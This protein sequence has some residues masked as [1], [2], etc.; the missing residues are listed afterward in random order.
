MHGR[1]NSDNIAPAEH[2]RIPKS[3]QN[4]HKS[5]R[6][7][8][9]KTFYCCNHAGAIGARGAGQRPEEAQGVLQESFHRRWF[10]LVYGVPRNFFGA[11]NVAVDLFAS[12]ATEIS[13][14]TA[15][16]V[17]PVMNASE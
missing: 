10:R 6:V 17:A 7:S 4:Q 5:E 1:K 14:L 9:E 15:L 16:T 2:L 12:Q 3:V 8:H 13:D 11:S